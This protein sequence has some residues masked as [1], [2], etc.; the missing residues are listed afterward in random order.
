MAE[1]SGQ[2]P[3]LAVPNLGELNESLIGLAEG[4]RAFSQSQVDSWK[5]LPYLAL[6]AEGTSGYS[7]F[8]SKLYR[9]GLLHVVGQAE[10]LYGTFIDCN[11][12][13]ILRQFGKL[14]PNRI[15]SDADVVEAWLPQGEKFNA[16]KWLEQYQAAAV[17]PHKSYAS[18]SEVDVREWRHATAHQLGLLSVFQRV[19]PVQAN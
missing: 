16:Q 17:E 15:A 11:N 8:R 14:E 6:Q 10:G 12:G 1:T 7:S 4:I 2:S 5:Q 13:N 18:R 9:H 3:E 19:Q